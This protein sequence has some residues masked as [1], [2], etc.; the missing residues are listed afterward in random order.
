MNIL[1]ASILNPNFNILSLLSVTNYSTTN[2]FDITDEVISF[3]MKYNLKPIDECWLVVPDSNDDFDELKEIIDKNNVHF[4]IFKCSGVRSL[5]S[6]ENI[7]KF[8]GLIYRAVLNAREK[9]DL[10]YLSSDK[11]IIYGD[12][13]EAAGIFGCDAMYFFDGKNPFL[14]KDRTESSL[15]ISADDDIIKAS[16]YPLRISNKSNFCIFTIEE[17]GILLNEIKIRKNNSKHLYANYY[18]M[19]KSSRKEREVFRKLYYL[20]EKT[21]E[22]L[23]NYKIGE[24][25]TK[26]SWIIQHLP[27]AELHSHI[28]GLLTPSE[29]IEVAKKAKDYCLQLG[30][31]ASKKFYNNVQTILE[32]ENNLTDFENLIYGKYLQKSNFKSIGIENYMKLGDFQGSGTLQL[33]DMISATLEIYAKHLIQENIQYVEIRC[34]PYKYTNLGLTI[35]EVV[36]TMIATLKKFSMS[37]EFRLIYIIVRHEKDDI[38]KNAINEYCRLYDNYPDFSKYFV[39]VDVAGNEKAKSPMALRDNFMPLLERCTKVTIHAGES[40]TVKSIWEAI[41]CLN[42]DRIGHGLNLKD[43]EELYKRFFDKKIGIELCPSSNDQIIG[44]DVGS[45]PLKEYMEQGLRVTINTDDCGISRTTLSNEFLK[46]AEMCPDLT[47]WDCIVL[48]R[49]SL[50]IAFCDEET[51]SKLMHSFEDEMLELFSEIFG[52]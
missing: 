26:D 25:K 16:K 51:K 42:A 35:E 29:I 7:E 48:I 33:K 39:A 17:D 10:L 43:K 30:S 36:E 27:K 12:V 22:K 13:Q 45:Y 20:P 4:N 5:S 40:D 46:A 9:A 24:N 52:E 31:D 44:F 15:I 11:S 23:K 14:I 6:Q 21:I 49:N 47:L 1:V 50:C 34:S 3:K 19:I 32:Y 37:F 2:Q 18:G 28:G 41:Y 38:L 8:R